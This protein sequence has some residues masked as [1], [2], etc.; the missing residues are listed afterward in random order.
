[1]KKLLKSCVSLLFVAHAFAQESASPPEAAIP[2]STVAD[3]AAPPSV[4]TEPVAPETTAPEKFV[5]PE[6]VQQQAVAAETPAEP[7]NFHLG[8]RSAFGISALRSHKAVK[9]DNLFNGNAVKLEP[10]ISGSVGLAFAIE[11]NNLL[12]VAP[13][14][15]YT[16]YRANGRYIQKT[17][18]S[19]IADRNEAGVTVHSLELPILARFSFGNLGFGNIYAEIGPQVGANLDERIY[20][21][22]ELKSPNDKNIFAFGPAAGFGIKAG[23]ILVGVRGYFGILEY[24]EN[25][26]G[27]PWAAQVSLTKLFF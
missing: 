8:I 24:A 22:S 7:L 10:A 4:A 27:Y 2:A 18:D 26:N 14:L 9:S 13:E 25:T 11:I 6:P 1:M 23:D 21:N 20:I 15:Q 16:F 17:K 19:F 5:V 3:S 12:A